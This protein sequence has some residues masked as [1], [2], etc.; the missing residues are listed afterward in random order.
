MPIRRLEAKALPV[1]HLVL[2]HHVYIYNLSIPLCPIFNLIHTLMF[3]SC[4]WSQSFF[5]WHVEDVDLYSVNY[6]HY[7]APKVTLAAA[8]LLCTSRRICRIPVDCIN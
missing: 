4:K 5:S 6:L 2:P 7:G 1:W 8:A 3:L